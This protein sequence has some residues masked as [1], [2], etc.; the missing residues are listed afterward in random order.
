LFRFYNCLWHCVNLA[1]NVTAYITVLNRYVVFIS[2][3]VFYYMQLSCMTAVMVSSLSFAAFWLDLYEA[4]YSWHPA[5]TSVTT[6]RIWQ[7]SRGNWNTAVVCRVTSTLQVS[8]SGYH[9][10]YSFVVTAHDTNPA[11]AI[12]CRVC[13][14]VCRLIAIFCYVSLLLTTVQIYNC[15]TYPSMQSKSSPKTSCLLSASDANKS[16]R[17]WG[18]GHRIFTIFVGTSA[19]YM[20]SHAL[21]CFI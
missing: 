21:R 2:C 18:Q 19:D 4:H 12:C 11:A 14:R 5:Q 17:I 3:L 13:S 9:P 1:L 16:F 8:T 15:H 7:T 20:F 10:W 6:G